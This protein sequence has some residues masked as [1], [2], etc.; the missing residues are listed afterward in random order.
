[1]SIIL[2]TTFRYLVRRSSV[3][4]LVGRSTFAR[5]KIIG[6]TG[7][8]SNNCIMFRTQGTVFSVQDPEF[9]RRDG[10]ICDIG[11]FVRTVHSAYCKETGV[12]GVEGGE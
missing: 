10:R 5:D 3:E 12:E 4:E 7:V 9:I 11:V 1:M 6:I 8:G 2:V